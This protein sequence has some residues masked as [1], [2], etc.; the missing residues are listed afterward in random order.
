MA[1][2]G[3]AFDIFGSSVSVR[4]RTALVG[5]E[6]DDDNGGD[7]GSA[8]VYVRSGSTW[9]EQAK[10]TASDGAAADYFGRSVSVSGETTV[11]GAP[12]SLRGSAYVFVRSGSPPGST[13]SQ[14]AKLTASDGAADDRFGRSVS[15]SGDTAVVG[16]VFDN[17]NGSESGSAYVFVRSGSPPGSTWSEQAKLTASDGAADDSFGF[18]VSVDADTAVVGAYGDDW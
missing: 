6:W 15:V 2:D 16:A 17:D 10:L 8:Y 1:S 9:T 13:W 5:A 7:S 3:A 11:V 4:G 12:G 18:S 14:Q